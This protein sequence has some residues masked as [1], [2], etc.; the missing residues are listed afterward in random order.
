M[1][2]YVD[3]ASSFG[4]FVS[5]AVGNKGHSSGISYPA[6]SPNAVSIGS[7]DKSD[8]ISDITN[9]GGLFVF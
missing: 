5:I 8:L 9:S 6:C 1:Y 4:M 2:S 7:S 3:V